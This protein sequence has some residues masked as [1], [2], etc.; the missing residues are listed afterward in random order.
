MFI[1]QK[2]SSAV[3]RLLPLLPSTWRLPIM[4]RLLRFTSDEEKEA[5]YLD[6]IGPGKG[7]AIDIG[8]NYGLYSLPLS[9]LYNQVVSFEPNREV[10]TPLIAARLLNVRIVHE[11]VSSVE[12]EAE[13]FIPVVNGVPLG[14]WASL[15]EKNCPHATSFKKLSITLRPLD[16]HG[17]TDV[18]FIKIDV[19]GHEL[20]VLR[21]GEKTI[22]RDHPT[23][24]IEV[25]DEHLPELRSLLVGWGYRETSLKELADVTGS[26]QNYLFV[27]ESTTNLA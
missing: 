20:E 27:A 16:S 21:G 14:G 6:K 4:I 24:L 7:M 23:L 19:E 8:A 13:F 22:R 17:L 5:F 12:G 15:D 3:I 26:P 1:L 11:G 10:A 18:G 2:L 25:R 9:R